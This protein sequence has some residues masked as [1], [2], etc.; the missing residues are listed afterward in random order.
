MSLE[1]QVSGQS[2][3]EIEV[4]LQLPVKENRN[5][6]SYNEKATITI[7]DE[8]KCRDPARKVNNKLEKKEFSEEKLKLKK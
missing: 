5:Y 7:D 6:Y 2:N 3:P 8:A 1:R 4:D